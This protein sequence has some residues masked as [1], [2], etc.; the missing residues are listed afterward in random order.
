MVDNPPVMVITGTSRGIGRG[1]AEYFVGKGYRV[2]GCS[3]GPAA[4]EIEGYQHAEVDVGDEEQVRDWI[5]SIKKAYQHID[6]LVCNAGIPPSATALALTPG[7]H[8]NQVLRTNLAGTFYACREVAKA[9]MLQKRGRIITIS[10]ITA[11]LHEEGTSVYSASK[12]AVT[13][14]TKVLAKELAPMGITCNVVAPSLT[15]TDAV[16]GLGEVVAAR[17]LSKQTFKRVI[18]I[19]EICN[20]V[21]F[22]A[23]PASGCITGQVVHMGLVS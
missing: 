1:M 23:A 8:L 10:S 14:M 15:T 6:V 3:R 11:D 4:L 22:F 13:E 19:D 18:T 12:S 16:E 9:M 7:Q 17:F 5:R 20:V 2:A 21:S